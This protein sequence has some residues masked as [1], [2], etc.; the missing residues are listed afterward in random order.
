MNTVS[1]MDLDEYDRIA[2]QEGY[3]PMDDREDLILPPLAQVV[4]QP[5]G[6][7]VAPLPY[8]Q[9]LHTVYNPLLPLD[10]QQYQR[11]PSWPTI[12]G[13][14][15]PTPA[16]SGPFSRGST[17]FPFETIETTRVPLNDTPEGRR[18]NNAPERGGLEKSPTGELET[19]EPAGNNTRGNSVR[20]SATPG[21]TGRNVGMKAYQKVILARICVEHAA[22]YGVIKMGDFWDMITKLLWEQAGYSLKSPR[23]TVFKWITLRIDEL[24]EEEM[25]SGTEVECDDFRAAVE[26]FAERVEAHKEE[27][28]AK[29]KTVEE[30]VREAH[31]TMRVQMSM[32]HGIDEED[33]PGVDTPMRSRTSTPSIALNKSSSKQHRS[34]SATILVDGIERSMNRLAD[35]I[36]GSQAPNNGNKRKRDR[37]NSPEDERD[38][39]ELVA[40][41]FSG[42]DKRMERLEGGIAKI[43]DK[44]DAF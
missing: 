21:A 20:G 42:I 5:Q 33:V 2:R 27:V 41:R 25:G 30:K 28:G 6:G 1:V 18:D 26:K 10:Q 11:S 37:S 36:Q 9:F 39:R 34:T 7:V 15:S 19:P 35:A 38:H 17:A 22:E 44:L 23:Q 32:L 24:V 3:P 29:A 12:R 31:E 13:A 43:L 4:Q 8:Q 16:P 14:S 40:Q